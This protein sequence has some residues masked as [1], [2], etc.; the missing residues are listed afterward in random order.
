MIVELIVE[1]IVKMILILIA[2]QVVELTVEL[3][4]CAREKPSHSH[5]KLRF[6]FAPPPSLRACSAV[7]RGSFKFP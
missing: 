3:I 2:E 5:V 1:P 4:T 7:K 6:Y